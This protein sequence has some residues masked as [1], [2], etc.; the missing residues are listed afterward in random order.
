MAWE[1]MASFLEVKPYL[2]NIAEV[3]HPDVVL[4]VEE[5]EGV[6]NLYL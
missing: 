1:D 2:M 3:I 6:Q 4:V 5:L